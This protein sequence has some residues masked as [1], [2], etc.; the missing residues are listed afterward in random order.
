MFSFFFIDLRLLFFLYKIS[1]TRSYISVMEFWLTWV[2]L[3]IYK[4][5]L[6][7]W[8][9]TCHV[10][11]WRHWI[12][13]NFNP[14]QVDQPFLA[15]TLTVDFKEL[16]LLFYIWTAK[17]MQSWSICW[18]QVQF[19]ASSI[20]LRNLLQMLISDRCTLSNL[21]LQNTLTAT[22]TIINSHHTLIT[23]LSI[24]QLC[25]HHVTLLCCIVSERVWPSYLTAVDITI[26]IRQ[27]NMIVARTSSIVIRVSPIV[28]LE[29][30]S[31]GFYH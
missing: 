15:A 3:T 14:S 6:C 28:W 10:Q 29:T 12:L 5:L 7:V 17:H 18:G 8:V 22:S 11:R 16:W 13:V 21:S 20:Y 27:H 19:R 24:E 2:V 25:N 26:N 1:K 23:F 30:F 4:T 31:F 9:P